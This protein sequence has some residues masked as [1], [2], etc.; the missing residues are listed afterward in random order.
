MHEAWRA[1]STVLGCA[2]L[3]TLKE[4]LMRAQ[5][6]T[7]L[8]GVGTISAAAPAEAQMYDPRYPVCMQVSTIDGSSTGCGYS[9]MAECAA[10][11]SGRAAQCFANPYFARATKPTHVRPRIFKR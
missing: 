6:W 4:V 8:L 10:S 7:I 2:A 9:T 11:A 5:P 3:E 1:A